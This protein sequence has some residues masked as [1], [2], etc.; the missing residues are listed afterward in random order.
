MCDTMVALPP[1][2]AGGVV[3]FAKNSD[4][5]RDEAQFLDLVPA[6]RHAEGAGLRC[7]YIDIPQAARTHAVL[8]SRPYWLWG[9][10]MGA[11]EHGV[12][13]G[14]EAVFATLPPGR[15][16]A[17]IG[18][19]LVR[20]GLERAATAAEAVA[21]ITGL[22]EAHGQ[23]GNCGHRHEH[24]YDNSFLIADATDAFVL[25]TVGR[26]W[27][28][29]RCPPVRAISNA[30]SI[31]RGRISQAGGGLVEHARAQGWCR[32]AA[33]LDFAESYIDLERDAQSRGRLR[34]A[35]A[36]TLLKRRDGRLTAADMMA[37]LRDHGA[38]ADGTA[39]WHPDRSTTRAICM[40]AGAGLRRGQSVG[41]LV[42]ELHPD[43]PGIYWVTGT[44]APCLS[45]FKPVLFQ[46]GLPPH[47]PQPT[48]AADD[49]SLW[50]RH[51][52]LHRRAVLGDH[53]AALRAIGGERDAME[54]RFAARVA[55]LGPAPG[56]EAARLVG[57]CWAE[58]A[59]AEARWA[60]DLPVAPPEAT[61]QAFR[62]S[63]ELHRGLAPAAE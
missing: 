10:E 63:W 44:S 49:A 14:N 41:S 39:D 30:L 33:D 1:A 59:A 28:V 25:E 26:M 55:G 37:T 57:E 34:C 13:I 47:G 11:N 32:D 43:R 53:A 27:A 35:R 58:A 38:E 15:T 23:G 21:V 20:L 60:A 52:R 17:L 62:E 5:E 8:L 42:A 40:H 29:E 45:I 2:T 9:A 61:S 54:T 12:V 3:L 16:P 18:M 50:W 22:L 6:A 4:R 36:T 46:S 56:E 51:E 24:F 48:G 31:G 19:D 7:T